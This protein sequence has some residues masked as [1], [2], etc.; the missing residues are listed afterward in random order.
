MTVFLTGTG[1]VFEMALPANNHPQAA[2]T[3]TTTADAVAVRMTLDG[4]RPQA[5]IVGA[6][7]LAS[8]SNYLLGDDPRRWLT[9]VAHYA[10]VAYQ[11]IYPG[12]DLVYY[13]R[14]GRLR[15]DFVVAP[16]ADP[17]HIQLRYQGMRDLEITATGDLLAHV[18]QPGMGVVL[19]QS[20]PFTY[21]DIAG[22]RREVRSQFVITGDVITFALG[23]YD[24]AAPLIIDPALVY[25]TFLGGSGDDRAYAV[26]VDS[27]GAVYV[28]GETRSTNFPT[29]P[30]GSAYD[31]TRGGTVDVFVTKLNAAGTALVYS[32][33]LG[34][35]ANDFGYGLAVDSSGAAYIVGQ[36]LSTNFPTLNA[37]RSTLSGTSDAFVTKLNAA[38]T[39]LAYS[40][41]LGGSS[42]ESGFAITVDASGAAYATGQTSSSNFPTQTPYDGTRN[43][44]DA[45]VAK[46]TPAGTALAFSTFLGGS[47]S[48]A[49]RGIA[50][51]ASGA[52]Y[53]AGQT[54][55]TNFPRV[56]AAQ[57]TYGAGTD[58][59]ITKFNAT[60]NTL[61]YSTYLGGSGSD[62][63][64]AIALDGAG[65]AYVT[66][67]TASTNFPTRLPFQA[68]NGGGT[69]DAFV[70]KLGATG[71]TL[72]YSTYLGGSANDVG[73]ALAVDSAG[74]AL[75]VGDTASGHTA[76]RPFPRQDALQNTYGGGTADAFITW[77]TAAGDSLTFSTFLG[78]LTYDQARGVRLNVQGEAFVVGLTDSRAFP[79]TPGAY[80]PTRTQS[81]GQDDAFVT[82]LSFA[83]P[84]IG[85]TVGV[86]RSADGL[87][88]LRSA[89]A[90]GAA[91]YLIPYGLPS[92]MAL[93]GDWDGDD[94]DTV[95]FYRPGTAFFSLSDQPASGYTFGYP[96]ATAHYFGFGSLGD[97]PLA[98][99]WDGDGSDSVGVYRVSTQTFYLRNA[100][101]G[102]FA[103]VSITILFAQ[104]GDIPL[105][106][107]WNDDGRDTP[108]LYRPSTSTFYLIDQATTGTVPASGYT[109][110]VGNPGDVPLV[111]DWDGDGV[112]TPG[113][114]RSGTFLLKNDLGAG[115]PF[116]TFAFGEAGDKPLSGKWRGAGG[117]TQPVGAKVEPEAAPTFDPG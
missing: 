50:V 106:G 87:I 62:I 55:S 31:T 98:G 113:V 13:S 88:A 48:E 47:S 100:K 4:A 78:G 108:A 102:G 12:I 105:V 86:K 9:G 104:P 58:A 69:R 73:H 79:T 56:N 74:N 71:N 97:L 116:V 6:G 72:D 85:D 61:A 77:L 2:D 46:F 80:K 110:P 82:K 18:G 115:L 27:S 90:A 7:K 25:S 32:T 112:S 52:V 3:T 15:Y 43:G 103:D 54:A 14:A 39:G 111:G 83:P 1:A 53:V 34:G 65:N 40:T 91:D 76:T 10:S 35:S 28:T 67:E 20:A 26:A 21:Q 95:G 75:V 30:S 68:A 29:A 38:G 42:T 51:D 17:A 41:Y 57:T 66:G 101:N 24:P 33:Y 64:R 92:D 117:G 89:L 99:D 59:F 94:V 45:F 8:A 96:P 44:S 37:L 107:D 19:T 5:Q 109:I 114:F 23:A 70:A 11:D 63:A 93:V 16:G 84:V 60:G 49:G 81:G 36:T 22:A